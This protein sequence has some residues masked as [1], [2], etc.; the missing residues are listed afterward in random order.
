MATI[1]ADRLTRNYGSHVAVDGISF[2][3]ERGEIVGFLGP[4][5]AG[6]TTTMKVLTGYLAPTTGR[7]LVDGVDVLTDPIEV[8]RRIGYL[9]E[10]A[11]IY[12]D[13]EVGDYLD[14]V[15]RVR[16]LARA[17]RARAIHRVAEQ[18]GIAD[19][20][21][22]D[23]GSLSKGFRQ[24]V[25]LAQ[26]LVHAPDILVLDEPT[27]G[28]DP[29]QIVE[30]RNLIREIGRRKT[31]LL[32]THILSEVQATCDRVLILHRGRIVADGSTEEISVHQQGGH[33][34]LATFAPGVVALPRQVVRE[35]VQGIAGVLRVGVVE[36]AEP[37]GAGF[38][39]VAERDVRAD[40][41]RLAADLGLVI[42]D[43][44]RETT[45]L[46]EVFG[47][48]TRDPAPLTGVAP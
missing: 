24:R 22:Q 46:E 47:R 35:A 32:S 1:E 7:A 13:M 48:L 36:V 29:N 21:N 16:G 39:V 42:L 40:L 12:R 28:L 41:F 26:A 17:E 43:L 33:L 9:P 6:K 31:V 15:A 27:S 20:L 30:I 8:R 23:I 10:S 34:I 5:A 25:G 18:C 14:F 45:S 19:R 37:E 11:P 38:Q 2:T 4:N 44:H 3:V